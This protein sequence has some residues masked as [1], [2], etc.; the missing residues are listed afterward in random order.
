MIINRKVTNLSP[1]VNLVEKTVDLKVGPAQYHCFQQNDYV[2]VLAVREDGKIPIVRQFRAAIE[3]FNWEL[4]GGIVDTGQTPLQACRQE[5]HEEAGLVVQDVY[6][7]GAHYPDCGRLENKIH[8][9]LVTA[10]SDP[11]FV[12]EPDVEPHFVTWQELLNMVK[13]G[14]FATALHISTLFLAVNH[15][16]FPLFNKN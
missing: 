10:T 6:D 14:D 3:Q 9:F 7:L 8:S 11:A 1:W 2:A 15:P 16:Q 12:P 13:Q 4:P 5:L